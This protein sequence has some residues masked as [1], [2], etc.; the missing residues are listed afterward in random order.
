MASAN[1]F[2]HVGGIRGNGDKATGCFGPGHS[3]SIF[4]VLYF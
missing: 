4:I 3:I 2:L 1:V